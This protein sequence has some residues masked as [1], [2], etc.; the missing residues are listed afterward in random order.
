MKKIILAILAVLVAGAAV[1][2]WNWLRDNRLPA[3]EGD[4]VEL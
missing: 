1:T 2:A 4:S 3:F